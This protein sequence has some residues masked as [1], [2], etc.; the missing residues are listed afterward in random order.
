MDA[1]VEFAVRNELK[2]IA[3]KH[4]EA[5]EER[6]EAWELRYNIY[7]SDNNDLWSVTMRLTGDHI[8]GRL[9]SDET[10]SMIK[11]ILDSTPTPLP[12]GACE[13]Y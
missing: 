11:S 10:M 1:A 6:L 2:R 4:V 8:V 5:L 7:P 12:I 9:P 13:D 3:R